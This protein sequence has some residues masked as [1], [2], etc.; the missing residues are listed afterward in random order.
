MNSDL[1]W[2]MGFG[3]G[4]VII[5]ALSLCGLFF[6]HGVF[7]I[8]S[9]ILCF[10]SGGYMIF[11]Y[12]KWNASGWSMIHWR[13]MLAY[14]TIAGMEAARAK[15]EFREFDIVS[16][17]R[18]LGLLIC[19]TEKKDNIEIMI[20]ELAAEEGS[21]F[22]NIL[23]E[24]RGE[25]LPGLDKDDFETFTEW[26]SRQKFGPTMVICNVVENTFG[27]IEAARYV[28]ALASGKAR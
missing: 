2:K 20:S 10:I 15:E 9:G 26:L 4:A 3:W 21:Y 18:D 1:K 11:Q 19:G 16:A 7:L 13:A 6:S 27:K 5:L 8:I 14:A 24:T 23:E 22:S 28:L 12:R 17:C 25:I